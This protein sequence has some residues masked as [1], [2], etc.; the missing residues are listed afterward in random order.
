MTRRN[1]LRYLGFAPIAVPAVLPALSGAFVTAGRS[2]VAW[3]ERVW[4]AEAVR[5]WATALWRSASR[6]VYYTRFMGGGDRI[7]VSRT[8]RL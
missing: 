5:R 3:R 1:F 4:R 7:I 8:R 6:E 2:V